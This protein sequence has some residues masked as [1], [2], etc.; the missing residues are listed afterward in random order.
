M[1]GQ[2]SPTHWRANANALTQILPDAGEYEMTIKVVRSLGPDCATLMNGGMD[3]TAENLAGLFQFVMPG[4]LDG[5][6]YL[7][8]EVRVPDRKGCAHG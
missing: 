2:N 5:A 1:R 6:R 3:C 7:I 8:V 4:A